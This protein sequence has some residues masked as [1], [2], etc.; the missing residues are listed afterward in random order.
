M[1]PVYF[2]SKLLNIGKAT[3]VRAGFPVLD[4]L[5]IN[6]S[7]RGIEF[8]EAG[9]SLRNSKFVSRPGQMIV[10]LDETFPKNLTENSLITRSRVVETSN[11]FHFSIV[12]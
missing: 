4:S 8:G 11:V 9:S 5:T 10:A 12:E 6:D 1:W 2:S 3:P 7:T